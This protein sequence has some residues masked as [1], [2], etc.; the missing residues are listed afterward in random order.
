M[1]SHG[2][3]TEP[4]R[5]IW[6][7][8]GQSSWRWPPAAGYRGRRREQLTAALMEQ[9]ARGAAPGAIV[10]R[11]IVGGYSLLRRSTSL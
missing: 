2:P 11:I 7:M 1:P 10:V 6:D 9:L 5:V 4:G 3:I 8:S